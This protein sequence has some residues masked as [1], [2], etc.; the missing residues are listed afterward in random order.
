MIFVNSNMG[1]LK[2]IKRST[3]ASKNKGF[4]LQTTGTWNNLQGLRMGWYSAGGNRKIGTTARNQPFKKTKVPSFVDLYAFGVQ[5]G[6]EG[7]SEC[8]LLRMKEHAVY[9]R[10]QGSSRTLLMIILGQ[11]A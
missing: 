11:Q 4:Y 8:I 1:I 10:L 7:R 5:S 2:K 6:E 3:F 9:G